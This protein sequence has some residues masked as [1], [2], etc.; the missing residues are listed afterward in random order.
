MDTTGTSSPFHRG[1]QQAQQKLGVREKIESV[2][3]RVI[4][5]YLLDQHRAFYQQLPFIFIGHTDP[6]GWPWASILFN[7]AGFVTA[8]SD[9]VLAINSSPITGDPLARSLKNDTPLGLLGIDLSTRRRNRL[10]GHILASQQNSIKLAV[11][12]SFGN[13]PKYIQARELNILE[14][15]S[16]PAI[17][18]EEITS[19]DKAAQQWVQQSDT[20]FVAS[21]TKKGSDH[22]GAGADVSHRGGKPGFIRIDSDTLLTIPDYSG[23]KH[24]NTLG[25]FIENPKAGLLFLDFEQGHLLTLTGT[26]EIVWDSPELETFAGAERL[27]TFRIDHGLKI[28]HGLPLRWKL[29]EPS[30]YCP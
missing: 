14:P 23:N 6:H 8:D 3:Q 10:S 19:L 27:W 24:F 21:A 29:N 17:D 18:V 25:N 12:Q 26:V 1:E 13:C 11:D 5:N 28:S 9:T 16:M 22:S 7:E 4:R 20:F 2:G 15:G 30:P